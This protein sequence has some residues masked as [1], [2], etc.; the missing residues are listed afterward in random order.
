MPQYTGV[1]VISQKITVTTAVTLLQIKAGATFPL[2]LIRASCTNAGV[3]TSDT[4]HIEILR[5]SAAA[6]VTSLTPKLLNPT[7]PVAK[8]VGGTAATGHTA[9]GEGTDGDILDEEGVNVLN[10]YRMLWLPE[11]R[12]VIDAAGFI[13][14]RSEIAVTS[15]DLVCVMVFG[16]LG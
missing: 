5:K 1:Y 11:E 16:E 15:V 4:A 6:T 12:P 10:G 14:M 13:A 8:A 3:E 2:H 7:Y 9:T